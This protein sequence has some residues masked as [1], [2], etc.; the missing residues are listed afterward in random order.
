MGGYGIVLGVALAV[1]LA[2]TPVVR[3]L[4]IR[5]GAVVAPSGDAR[6]VHTRPTPTL[7]GAAMFVGF[8]AAMAVASHMGQFHEMFQDNS[9]PFGVI[10]AAGVMFMVGALDDLIDVSPPAKVAGQVVAASLLALFGVS[11]FYFRMPF[12]LFGTDVVALSS[13]WTPLVTALWVVLM[14]N[15]INLIDGLDGLAAGIVAIAGGAL[16]LFADQLFDAGRLEGS[17][18]A[19]LIAII[20]VG[21]CLGFLPF[22]WN[23]AKIIMGDA[24]AL[25]LGLLLAVPTI[26]I[27]GRTD[28]AFSGST[29][30]FFAPLLIPLVI[31]G[32]PI[33]DTVFS[34]VRRITSRQKWSV[35]DAGHLHHRLMRLGHG[36]RRAVAILW[37]FT[38]LL[39]GVALLPV[40]TD[41]GNAIVPFIAALLGARHV[42]VVPPRCAVG[43]GSL[44][45]HAP[46]HV[47]G[48]ARGAVGRCHRG[49]PRRRR[50][51]VPPPQTR[52][53]GAAARHPDARSLPRR[54]SIRWPGFGLTHFRALHRLRI[55]SQAVPRPSRALCTGRR[56]P[57]EDVSRRGLETVELRDRQATYNGF[58]DALAHAT[59]LVVTP[60]LFALAGFGLDRWLGTGPG[61]RDRVRPHRRRRR[62]GQELLRV[63]GA[64]GP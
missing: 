5:L 24:G 14:T 15:A 52:L 37:A 6:H 11:M 13:D 19:P 41:K 57:G 31:L 3:M 35:A 62:R 46:P 63:C 25:F 38:A 60:L 53:N 40:Y 17:N 8:L 64:H 34:F 23:P 61:A 32:V 58:G 21:I 56:V 4:A 55:H 7:G 30:F 9:E 45:S 20:A 42:R 28:F 50:P 43:A 51:R 44:R 48:R 54:E 2:L 27:G 16:F 26:T 59:E 1:T 33:L 29:Y 39:S 47:G 22:N 36:P 10:L 18:I 12:N 49:A